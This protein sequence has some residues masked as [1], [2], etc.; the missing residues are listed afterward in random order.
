M[1]DPSAALFSASRVK[2]FMSG[3]KENAPDAAVPH[4]ALRADLSRLG[5]AF[6]SRATKIDNPRRG[7]RFQRL[8]G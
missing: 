1:R 7:K 3:A 6:R 4:P 5:E 2:V 8:L